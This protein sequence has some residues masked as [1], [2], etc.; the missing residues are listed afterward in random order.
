VAHKDDITP[1]QKLLNL[2]RGSSKKPPKE[3]HIPLASQQQENSTSK[4]LKETAGAK[5]IYADK[6]RMSILKGIGSHNL[7]LINRLILLCV[8]AGLLFLLLD[9]YST[10][11][12]ISQI[13]PLLSANKTEF[14]LE[15][16][17]KKPYS[18]YQQEI[19]KR[20][21]FKAD[22]AEARVNK[23]VPTGQTF[24]ELVKDLQLLGIMSGDK[25]Q[26]IIEDK[27]LNKTYFLNIGDYLGEIKLD[28]I[29]SDNVTLE[30]N[31]EKI[32]LFL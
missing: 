25:P 21:L 3:K 20:N 10:P 4:P 13:T 16:K 2:I 14:S 19:S 8:F 11:T 23:V 12:D 24:K 17:E 30:F 6:E 15:T 9:L 26:A 27:K 31:G 28:A 5:I 22:A 18:Y 29:S 32:T 1:E 7:I